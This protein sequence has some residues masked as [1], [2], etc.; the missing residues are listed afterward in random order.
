MKQL[1]I[2]FLI[3]FSLQVTI[4]K[5]ALPQVKAQ[6]TKQIEAPRAKEKK[7]GVKHATKAKKPVRKAP[8]VSKSVPKPAPVPSSSSVA[9]IITDA[10]NRHGIDPARAL[11]IATCESGLNVLARNTGYYAGGGNPTGLFQ[12]LPETWQR[13][14]SRSPYGVGDIYSAQDQANVTMWAWANGYAG[15]WE[16]Q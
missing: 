16:C 3:V 5:P 12:Y 9:S 11:R 2:A 4:N 7:R 1:I 13:I 6:E 10:A 14:G 15:E 8:V